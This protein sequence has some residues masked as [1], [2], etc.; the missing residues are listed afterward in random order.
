MENNRAGGVGIKNSHTSKW[1]EQVAAG[2]ET[3]INTE[4]HIFLNLKNFLHLPTVLLLI[5]VCTLL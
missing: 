4:S 5:F 1:A 2:K 3:E